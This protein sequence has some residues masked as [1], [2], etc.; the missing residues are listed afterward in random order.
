M[1][2]FLAYTSLFFITLGAFIPQ[3][4]QAMAIAPAVIEL[5]GE[6]GQVLSFEI[7]VGNLANETETY[8][9]STLKFEATSETGSPG[10]I[11]YEV[12]HSGL[13]EWIRIPESQIS[14]PPDGIS[15]LNINIAIPDD[16]PSGGYYAAIVASRSAGSIGANVIVQAQTAALVLL[17]VTGEST[18]QAALL[19]LTG[20]GSTNRLPAD[21][22]YRIQNQGNV[23]LQP[24]GSIKI[25]DLFG[26]EV[27]S[28]NANPDG[29]RVLPGST[30]SYQV[31]WS[32]SDS[33][34]TGFFNEIAN[35][36]NNFGLGRYKAELELEYTPGQILKMQTVFWIMPWRLICVSILVVLV[37]VL[38]TS[39]RS[40]ITRKIET[41]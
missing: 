40:K 37:L 3:P 4:T 18:E 30:R 2:R 41:E 12:D 10:F 34:G 13:A 33:V 5:E 28:V 39:L 21:F 24:T 27:A 31:I 11:P 22:A 15:T 38:A 6:R 29:G 8:H 20:P 35:E 16:V 1:K 32:R 25:Y 36:W 19:D 9:L 7:A 23:H 14:V 17:T 26:S